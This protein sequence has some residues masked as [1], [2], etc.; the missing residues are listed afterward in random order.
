MK[1]F[2]LRSYNI[3]KLLFWRRGEVF[4]VFESPFKNRKGLR[5]LCVKMQNS[6]MTHVKTQTG[7]L[8]YFS[9]CVSWGVIRFVRFTFQVWDPISG[10]LT[11]H[12]LAP[13][14][15]LQSCCT[16]FHMLCW[17][18]NKIYGM[19]SSLY[20]LFYSHDSI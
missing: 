10:V 1:Y 17:Q 19:N 8:T 14:L 5:F 2:Y 12:G 6:N 11:R 9:L 3:D 7:V 18:F 4:E 20:F 16:L 13:F 15:R